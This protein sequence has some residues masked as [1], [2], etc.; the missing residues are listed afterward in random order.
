MT[1]ERDNEYGEISRHRLRSS[2]LT[3][4]ILRK[5]LIASADAAPIEVLK[6]RAAAR[7][8]SALH[9]L[10]AK[11]ILCVPLSSLRLEQQSST[12]RVTSGSPINEMCGG[13]FSPTVINAREWCDL[14]RKTLLVS[15][16]L[17]RRELRRESGRC[18][19]ATRK[20]EDSSSATHAGGASHFE[21]MEADGNLKIVCLYPEAQGLPDHS[22]HSR[23][24]G[25]FNPDRIASTASRRTGAV[26][27]T[28]QASG[29]PHQPNV[30]HQETGD[31]GYAP[32]RT[33][34]SWEG[35]APASSI[36]R[37]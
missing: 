9:A 32:R 11:G 24:G 31:A 14:H 34:R 22:S 30:I 2:S 28:K 19:S 16:F 15:Q 1:A 8:A 23:T 6:M 17:G 13:G 5:H 35:R 10:R 20:A 3:I 26:A 18:L 7:E 4:V 29:V 21:A 37:R 27:P 25:N 33:S 36:F 12:V